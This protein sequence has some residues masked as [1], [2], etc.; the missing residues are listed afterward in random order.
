MPPIQ[1]PHISLGKDVFRVERTS[2]AVVLVPGTGIEP[3]R[4]FSH[5]PLKM[6]CL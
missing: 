6:A 1:N 3:A 4:D 2:T 5:H